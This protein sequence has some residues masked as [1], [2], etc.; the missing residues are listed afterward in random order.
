MSW[1]WPGFTAQVH[2][3]GIGTGTQAAGD[4]RDSPLKYTLAKGKTMPEVAGDGRDSPLKYTD[5]FP[6]RRREQAG[7]G[8][9]SPLKYTF[10]VVFRCW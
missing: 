2:F 9:D 4:G 6:D 7:D 8:R 1:G 3:E 10:S 5:Q